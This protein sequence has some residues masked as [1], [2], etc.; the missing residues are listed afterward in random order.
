LDYIGNAKKDREDSVRRCIPDMLDHNSVLYIG[1]NQ[2][3]QH[4]LDWFLKSNYDVT[5]VEAFKDNYEYLKNKFSSVNVIHNDIRKELFDHSFDIIF[6]WHGIEHLPLSEIPKTLQKLESITDKITILGMPYGKY[7][8]DAEYG[9]EFEIHL[10][11]IYPEFLQKQ[12][13]DY[14]TL[15][16]QDQRGAHITAWKRK[17]E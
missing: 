5:I 10:S 7:L 15:G 17:P 4:F 11:E 2:H 8:Q 1:A 14:E 16:N 6:F 12:G 13:Y 9:N 3:R